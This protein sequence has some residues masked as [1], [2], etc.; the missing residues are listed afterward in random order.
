[1]HRLYH[2]LSW[3]LLLASAHAFA[4]MPHRLP[5]R[6]LSNAVFPLRM[7]PSP[8]PAFGADVTVE[9]AAR[10]LHGEPWFLGN[11]SGTPV[12]NATGDPADPR[13]QPP[14]RATDHAFPSAAITVAA[15]PPRPFPGRRGDPVHVDVAHETVD[16]DFLDEHTLALATDADIA[17]LLNEL[18]TL[19]RAFSELCAAI[20]RSDD[21]MLLERDLLHR[22]TIMS[23]SPSTEADRRFVERTPVTLRSRVLELANR[24]KIA[25]PLEDSTS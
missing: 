21:V 5:T 7:P 14:T 22:G 20:V 8:P 15:V 13:S 4:R 1:M 16:D 19:R 25:L 10:G 9:C 2:P 11:A 3:I 6:A 12:P 17:C 23:A 24:H 18:H